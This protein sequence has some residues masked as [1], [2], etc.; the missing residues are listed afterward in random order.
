[1][2]YIESAFSQKPDNSLLGPK[3]SVLEGASVNILKKNLTG[4]I[5]ECGV[6]KGGS[7]RLLATIFP[8]K[9]I[10]LFDSFEGIH[11]NDVLPSGHRKGDF[12]DTSLLQVKDYLDDKPNC[13]F[14][15]GWLPESASFLTDEKFS[16]VHIDLDLY[17][18]TKAAINLF[19]PKLVE[20]GV[21]VFNNYKRH[22]GLGVEKAIL[23]Y[24]D[25]SDIL[26]EKIVV[27]RLFYCIIHKFPISRQSV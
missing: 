16:L 18:S 27:D 22:H 19:W 6:Y 26:Y 8:N 4:D 15:P 14:F 25:N 9:K 21:M 11:E 3:M 24:F 23:E 10:F 5:A 17:E 20:G 1:M 13:L 2:S 7:A 12:S